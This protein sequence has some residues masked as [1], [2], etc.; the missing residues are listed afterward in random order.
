MFDT[1]PYL[2]GMAVG[3]PAP[4]QGA[5]R[6]L[7]VSAFLSESRYLSAGGGGGAAASL[8]ANGG[9]HQRTAAATFAQP[10]AAATSAPRQVV[11]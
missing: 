11:Y 5:L 3:S 10:Y 2:Q 1:W 4:P 6:A 8:V 9:A 7:E